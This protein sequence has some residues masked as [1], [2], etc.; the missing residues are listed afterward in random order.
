MNILLLRMARLRSAGTPL[1]LPVL[2]A[3]LAVVA[4]DGCAGF[5]RDGGFDSVAATT[6][7]HLNQAVSWPRTD[8]E[9]AKSDAQVAALLARPLSQDD[10][11]QVALLNNRA[12]RAAFQELGISEAD[13][14]QSGRLPN[15]RFDL[16]HAGASGQYDIQETLTFNVLSLLAMPYAHEIQARRFEQAQK[17]AELRILQVA[18]DTREAYIGAIAAVESLEYQEQVAKAAQS[19]AE[20]AARMVAAGNWNRLDLAREQ[21]FASNALQELTHAQLLAA[22]T[23][24]KLIRLLGLQQDPSAEPHPALQ[25]PEHLPIL[26]HSIEAFPDIERTVLQGRGDLQLRRL[27]LDELARSLKLTNVTRFI[28]V[29]DIGPT[30]IKQGPRREPYEKG[31]EFSLEVPIFDSGAARL[32]KAEAIYAQAVDRFAQAAIDARSEIRQAY[33]A[34]QASFD[35][36]TQ[37]RDEVLPQRQAVADQ[38]LLRYN[39]SLI[40][41]FELLADA[42]EQVTGVD[43]YMQSVRDFW[44]AKSELDAT[45]LGSTA[46]PLS[47]D[48]SW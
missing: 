30:R 29:L 36:A 11:V 47:K 37:Q 45:L 1:A 2:V 32:R 23:R 9:L 16:V 7:T 6:R 22:A 3:L 25:L 8:G 43:A 20:L 42:R 33:A 38:N 19:G 12:L 17:L 35:L 40:S 21:S 24:E 39:A 27:E 26:P 10:A 46:S 18:K 31:F 5:S 15:P 48:S 14:V 44:I 34:Y 41:I 28:D 13:L 4:L